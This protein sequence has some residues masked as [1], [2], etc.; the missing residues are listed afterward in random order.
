MVFPVEFLPGMRWSNDEGLIEVQ[1]APTGLMRINRGVFD[2]MNP[3]RYIDQQGRDVGAFFR[4]DIREY[5]FG[6]DVEF[7]R[8]WRELGGRVRILADAQLAHWG[9]KS[10]T[11]NIGSAMKAGLA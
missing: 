5:Y 4:C 8:G 3:P 6:E 1:M 2:N 10:W 7:C 11:G 9:A